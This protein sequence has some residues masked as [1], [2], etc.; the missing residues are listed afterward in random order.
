MNAPGLRR[1]AEDQSCSAV[2]ILKPKPEGGAG[3]F[4]VDRL[5]RI[6]G[7]LSRSKFAQILHALS[8]GLAFRFYDV[9]SLTDF[10]ISHGNL[11]L[12]WREFRQVNCVQPRR[13]RRFVTDA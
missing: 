7:G 6:E 2:D 11:L 13:R 9:L 8:G 4:R 12:D 5:V 3:I 1:N 10:S